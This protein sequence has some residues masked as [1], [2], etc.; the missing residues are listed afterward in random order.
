[1]T[2]IEKHNQAPAPYSWTKSAT[3]ILVKVKRGRETANKLHTV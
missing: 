2:F 1:M 3:D